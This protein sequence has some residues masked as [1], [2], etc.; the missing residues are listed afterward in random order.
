[1]AGIIYRPDLDEARARLAAWW[2]GEDIGRPAMQIHIVPD[3]PVEDPGLPPAM[4]RP[5]GWVTDYSTTDYDYRV[6]IA[7]RAFVDRMCMAEAIP[8]VAPDVGPNTLALYLGCKGVEMPG[9]V[10]FKSFIHDPEPVVPEFKFDPDNFYWKF[11][12]RLAMDLARFG[13]G[14]FQQQ[15]PDFIEGLDTLAAMRG[16]ERLLFDLL[17]RPEWVHACLDRITD[18]YFEYY[19][20]FYEIMKDDVGGSTYWCWAPGRMAKFQCDFSAMIS[21]AMYREF[22]LPRLRKM[23]S[24][25]DHCIYHLDGPDAVRHHG[26]LLE[27]EDLDMIQ[28]IPGDGAA[29][30]WDPCWWPLM[31][32]IVDAGKKIMIGVYSTDD[33]LALKREFG[34]SFHNFL[35]GCYYRMERSEAERLISNL[36]R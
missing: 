34:R 1:M 30:A 27:I 35:L 19:D 29:P 4:P 25:V 31:H 8:V 7:R 36:E 22:M 14:R 5:D 6:N 18:V 33:I 3:A 15:F 13:K 9:T 28:W 12:S 23:V 24:K 2:N 32:E 16:S 21:P 17:E 11:T 20:R 10:W 26:M